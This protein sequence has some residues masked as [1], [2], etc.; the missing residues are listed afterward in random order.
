MKR[1]I[2]GICIGL[3]IAII[4]V[5]LFIMFY[6]KKSENKDMLNTQNINTSNIENNTQE[7]LERFQGKTSKEWEEKIKEYHNL[8]NLDSF[9]KIECYYNDDENFTI[10]VSTQYE[11]CAEYVFD[12]ETG[13]ATEI[14]SKDIIS[15]FDK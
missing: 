5:S 6:F 9:E 1:I 7:N 15:T 4:I 8:N 3:C 11:V 13:Y 2:I 12:K 10:T 14:Y